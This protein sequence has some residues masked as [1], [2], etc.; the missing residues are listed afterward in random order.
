[1]FV[2]IRG[3]NNNN[4]K[5]GRIKNMNNHLVRYH[6]E[7]L[8][9]GWDPSYDVVGRRRDFETPNIADVEEENAPLN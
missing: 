6:R 2:R 4:K 5:H 3:S 9:A 1:M 7:W 8:E